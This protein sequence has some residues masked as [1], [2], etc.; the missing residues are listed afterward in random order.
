MVKIDTKDVMRNFSSHATCMKVPLFKSTIH[1]NVASSK[2]CILMNASAIE[3]SVEDVLPRQKV[4][5][6]LIKVDDVVYTSL[7]TYDYDDNVL[8]AFC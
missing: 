4:I 1:P 5:F 3:E 6:E 7:F 8:H 2:I